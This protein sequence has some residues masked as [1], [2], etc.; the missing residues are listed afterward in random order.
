ML[1]NTCE[2]LVPISEMPGEFFYDE[3]NMSLRSRER[4]FRISDSLRV[5]LTSADIISGKLAFAIAEDE[6]SEK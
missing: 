6:A 5:T 1:E 4:T 3:K 2:G